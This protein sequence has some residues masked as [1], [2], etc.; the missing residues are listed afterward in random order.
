VQLQ[1]HQLQ[2]QTERTDAVTRLVARV[3]VVT[4]VFCQDQPDLKVV[5]YYYRAIESR[6][7]T[8][9][10]AVHSPPT[11]EFFE[12]W[13]IGT[14]CFQTGVARWNQ[15]MGGA[16]V[17][18]AQEVLQRVLQ[19]I[20]VSVLTPGYVLDRLSMRL[21]DMDGFLNG[22]DGPP[23]IE[24]RIHP[25]LALEY[26][27]NPRF[28]PAIQAGSQGPEGIH[29][30]QVDASASYYFENLSSDQDEVRR[31]AINTRM[32]WLYRTIK[33]WLSVHS[34]VDLSK[35]L[36]L[37]S[38]FTRLYDSEDESSTGYSEVYASDGAEYMPDPFH[39]PMDLADDW[40]LSQLELG[41]MGW[42]DG[43]L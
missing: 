10:S 23:W 7:P 17:E 34:M 31:K 4:Y 33:L 19:H 21:A 25:H 39:G 36:E 20:H 14:G 6:K 26:R 42:V 22:P 5:D 1:K 40:T 8:V 35:K 3:N 15:Y 12:H 24:E 32:R 43:G 41:D 38:T 27:T 16:G 37:H 2:E 13:N 30:M 28:D 9:Y 29:R 18:W 11:R